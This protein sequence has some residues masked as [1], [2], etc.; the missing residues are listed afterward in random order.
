MTDA[1]SIWNYCVNGLEHELPDDND[2][3]M[4]HFAH[5][6]RTI[7]KDMNQFDK[8]K[9]PCAVCDQLGHTFEQCPVLQATDLKDAYLRLLILVKRFV[10]GL[11]K[12]D[13]TGKKHNNNLNVLKHVSLEQL[14]ALDILEDS[15][16]H[17]VS[18][19]VP[20]TDDRMDHVVNMLKEDF[21]PLLTQHHNVIANMSSFIDSTSGGVATTNQ[22]VTD[23]TNQVVTDDDSNGS[24][25][26]GSTTNDIAAYAAI[27]NLHAKLN[28]MDFWKA[29]RRK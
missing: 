5:A 29:G 1:D 27:N 9:Y 24:T 20:T 4:L 3:S 21:T 17:I 7:A 25:H 18:S 14:H 26:T 15:P 13:P 6:V 16:I 23:H 8:S 22:V 11:N 28:N 10:K 2:P 12:L 19:C